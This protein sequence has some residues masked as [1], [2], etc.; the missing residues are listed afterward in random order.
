MMSKPKCP[1]HGVRYMVHDRGNYRARDPR[2]VCRLCDFRT[3]VEGVKFYTPCVV[4]AFGLYLNVLL[5]L[6]H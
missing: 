1:R 5:T 3:W 6:H 4:L 2:F